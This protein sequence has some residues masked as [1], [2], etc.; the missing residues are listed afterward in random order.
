M[1]QFIYQ[2]SIKNV[3]L[4]Y[5]EHPFIYKECTFIYPLIETHGWP[6]NYVCSFKDLLTSDNF[7][8]TLRQVCRTFLYLYIQ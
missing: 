3:P 6:E 4:F 7:A 5:K 2:V 8:G 1:Q